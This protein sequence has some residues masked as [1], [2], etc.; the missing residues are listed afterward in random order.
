MENGERKGERGSNPR[1]NPQ[2]Q[3]TVMATELDRQRQAYVTALER[4]LDDLVD[5]L[6]AMPE[7]ERVILFGS[8]ATGRRLG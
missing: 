8:Y 3:V 2:E 5:Q 1:P 7:V 6:A 4:A